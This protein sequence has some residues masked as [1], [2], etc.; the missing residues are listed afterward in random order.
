MHNCVVRN[1][2]LRNSDALTQIKNFYFYIFQKY[3]MSLRI[4]IRTSDEYCGLKNFTLQI[5][6]NLVNT[7][8]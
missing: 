1:G 2:D 6:V 7:I 5:F 3:H 8:L 4:L